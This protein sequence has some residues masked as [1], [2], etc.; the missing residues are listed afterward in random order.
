M[1]LIDTIYIHDGGGK[2][3]LDYLIKN[4][5]DTK[6]KCFYLFDNRIKNLPTIK[7]TNQVLFL[8]PSLWQRF[9]FYKKHKTSFTRVF[10][11]G[12]LPPNIK[13]K[14]EVITYY[15]SP[16]YLK[17]PEDFSTIERIK[18]VLKR[19]VLMKFSKHSDSW[20]VQTNFIKQKL[21]E[22][23]RIDDSK[24]SLM[25]FFPAF[26]ESKKEVTRETNTFLYVSNATTH[27][28]HVRL[29]NAFCEFF[30]EHKIGKLTL[31]VSDDYKDVFD[32]I[33][34]KVSEGYPIS[35]VGFIGRKELQTLYLSSQYLIFPSIAE[36][37]G[38]GLVEAINSGCKVIGADLAYTYAVCEPSIVFNPYKESS[39]VNAFNQAINNE[40]RNSKSLIEDR[41]NELVELLIT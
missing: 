40:L 34:K 36:S 41:I 8:K 7:S 12:N 2:I 9:Q 39:I 28:N 27:K 23:F 20:L 35:N 21:E 10:C 1:L 3:L 15:H 29:I 26:G 24:V 19:K 32:L 37:F 5:E 25:P 18:Y 6:I 30:D 33:E 11:M 4:L 16:L 14:A 13:M 31:T 38:L 22:K 17:S